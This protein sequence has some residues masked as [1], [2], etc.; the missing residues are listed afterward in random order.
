MAHFAKMTSDGTTVLQVHAVNDSDCLDEDN[1]ESESV[2]IAY[3]TNCHGWSHWKQTSYNTVEGTHRLSGTPFRKNY[4]GIGMTYDSNRNA[5]IAPQPYSSW[6]LDENKCIWE[7]P[8]AY[9]E[10][11]D[12]EGN[13]ELYGW[14]EST[15]SWDKV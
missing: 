13:P 15:T 7:A 12:E 3:L 9:P 8:T 4:A 11:E 14:N 1:N 5:F 6:E 2:G 10:T